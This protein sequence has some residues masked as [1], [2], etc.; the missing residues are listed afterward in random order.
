MLNSLALI[1]NCLNK[2]LDVICLLR[3]AH[4]SYTVSYYLMI[5]GGFL[6]DIRRHT[7]LKQR[8]MDVVKTSKPF[9]SDVVCRVVLVC[10][11]KYF[12]MSVNSF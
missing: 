1:G 12:V 8:C 3:Y 11:D 6:A 5:V 4:S 10:T 7:T 2:V 9:L